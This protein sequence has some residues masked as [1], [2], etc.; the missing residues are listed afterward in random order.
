MLEGPQAAERGTGFM[1]DDFVFRYGSFTSTEGAHKRKLLPDSGPPFPQ[2]SNG[3]NDACHRYLSG[4]TK[5]RN[6]GL[7]QIHVLTKSTHGSDESAEQRF[8]R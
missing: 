8:I 2:L 6:K 4:V 5:S 1:S 3:D 7:H